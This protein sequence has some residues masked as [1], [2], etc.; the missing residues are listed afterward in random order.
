M[1]SYL[2][3]CANATCAVPEAYRELFLD[4]EEWVESP[5]GW[6]PGSLNLAQGFA[7]KF[8][9]PL[10]HGDVT[11]L[12]IDLE[13]D[14]DAR[15]SR[16]SATLPET[17][18]AKLVERHEKPFRATLVDRIAED[19]RR[20]AA[21][22]HVMLHTSPA[23]E[24]RVV[25]ET[26]PGAPLA[27]AVAAEW[28]NRLGRVELD[29]RMHRESGVTPLGTYLSDSFRQEPY[30]QI[31]LTVS[32]SFFLAG[33]PWKWEPLKKALMEHFQQAVSDV[34]PVNAPESLSTAP[35]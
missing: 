4:S 34:I 22:I 3:S 11:R 33:R 25:L 27:E 26:P 6:E 24:G 20:R 23:H 8:R 14:G 1:P 9:T 29:A 7:M 31:R 30:V 5:E 10:V 32:Q 28:R 15:W 18:R 17:T 21:V 2:F 13:Q 16:I 19:F 35:D 12:L